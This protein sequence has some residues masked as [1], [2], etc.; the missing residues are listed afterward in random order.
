VSERRKPPSH[1]LRE[2]RLRMP[3]PSG[4]GRPMGRQELA[5]AVNAYLATKGDDRYQRVAGAAPPG[6]PRISG[7]ARHR[8]GTP[9]REK[10]PGVLTATAQRLALTISGM[11]S[12]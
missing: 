1:L 9:A 8:R 12:R 2:A 11:P 5:D 7:A 4:S 10:P 6:R 3:S